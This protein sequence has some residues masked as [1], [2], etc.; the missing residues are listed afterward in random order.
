M[1][2]DNKTEREPPVNVRHGPG[3][4][5]YPQSHAAMACPSSCTHMLK[6]IRT[7]AWPAPVLTRSQERTKAEGTAQARS[8]ASNASS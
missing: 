5:G 3:N 6:K 7:S 2:A 4:A 1:S 8:R